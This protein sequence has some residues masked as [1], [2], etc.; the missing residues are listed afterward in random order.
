MMT[1]LE[2]TKAQISAYFSDRSRPKEETLE[3]LREILED[4]EI[5]IEALEVDLECE[6][7]G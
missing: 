5:M 3:G 2:S 4:I 7:R 1:D 6:R